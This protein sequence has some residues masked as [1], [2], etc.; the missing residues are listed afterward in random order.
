VAA[1]VKLTNLEKVFWPEEGLTKGDLVAYFDAVAPVMLPYL[2]DR[3]LTVKRYPDGIDGE[4]FFQ[5]NASKYTPDWVKT[6]TLPAEGGKKD[7]RYILCNDKRTLMWLANQAAI[8]LHPFLSKVDRLERPDWLVMDIDPLEGGFKESVKAALAAREVLRSHN[9][10]GLAKTSGGKGVHIYVP[11]VRR[12]TFAQVHEA[13]YRLSL[14]VEEEEPGLVTTRF[15]K[16]EREGKVFMDFTRNRPGAHVVAAFSPRARS[17]APVSFPIS[18]KELETT[19]PMD[20]TI[21]SVPK[22]IQKGDPWKRRRS[23]PQS[24]PRE[25]FA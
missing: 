25:L 7:V 5:K 4:S 23:A 16:S 8:E 21:A 11:L 9:I 10:D 19:D 1:A 20:F 15:K 17:G 12:H 3:S 2:R 24:L 13:G 14:E 6:I 18:W 22:M